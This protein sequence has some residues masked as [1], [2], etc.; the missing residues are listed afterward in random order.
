[1]EKTEKQFIIDGLEN[2]SSRALGYK[3]QFVTE[4]YFSGINGLFSNY[5][6]IFDKELENDDL[7]KIIN[8]FEE[9]FFA[10]FEENPTE[11]WTFQ[12]MY[13]CGESWE[14]DEY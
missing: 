5:R 6:N 2:V 9:K 11:E 8:D 14:T 10:E 7:L 13:E 1:M 3:R 12:D 4:I